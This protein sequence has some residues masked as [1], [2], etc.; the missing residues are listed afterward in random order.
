MRKLG[1]KGLMRILSKS[2]YS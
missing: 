2:R 1:H